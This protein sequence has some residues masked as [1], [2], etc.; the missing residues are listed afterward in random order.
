MNSPTSA[1]Q[2]MLFFR[3]CDWDRGLS[4]EQARQALDRVM[5]WFDG[6]N[7]R[8]IVRGGR[9]LARTGAMLSREKGEVLVDGPFAESKEVVGGYLIVEV[10]DLDEAVTIAR[11]CPTLQRG[12][13]IEV[14]PML[15]ECPIVKR[16]R[17]QPALAMA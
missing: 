11:E 15:D 8:G 5:A 1:S 17:E 6:L 14:R 16:L 12:I 4:P 3:G 10:D 7:Q 13:E 2:Y 9:P